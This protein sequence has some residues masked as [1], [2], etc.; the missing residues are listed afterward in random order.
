M[1]NTLIEASEDIA[2][3]L[4]RAA[5]CVEKS[6]CTVTRVEIGYE[7]HLCIMERSRITLQSAPKQGGAPYR[8]EYVLTLYRGNA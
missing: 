5:G 1:E 3:Q 4:E 7:Q 6:K 2:R 8:P